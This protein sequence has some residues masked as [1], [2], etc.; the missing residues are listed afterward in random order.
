MRDPTAVFVLEPDSTIFVDGQGEQ[1]AKRVAVVDWYAD[2]PMPHRDDCRG[3]KATGASGDV[4]I[5]E[6]VVDEL[7]TL[8]K[9][10]KEAGLA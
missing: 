7:I 9:I 5:P 1:T 3:Y 4:Y 2:N 6:D 8:R 10:E